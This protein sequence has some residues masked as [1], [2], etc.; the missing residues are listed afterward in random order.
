MIKIKVTALVTYFKQYN[1][2]KSLVFQTLVLFE[3]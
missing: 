3:L 2:K 1:R